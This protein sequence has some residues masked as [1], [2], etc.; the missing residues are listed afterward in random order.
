MKKA[1]IRA[2]AVKGTNWTRGTVRL[3]NG[4]TFRFDAK[5]YA[6]PSEYG[7]GG[8]RISK[9]S[10]RTAVRLATVVNYDRGWDVEPRTADHRA[11][12]SALVERYN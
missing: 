2:A 8:G 9:L 3:A 6:E 11:V 1:M 12:L 5:H 4:R 7:I 10:V